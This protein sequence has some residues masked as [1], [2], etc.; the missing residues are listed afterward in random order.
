M[1]ILT[2]LSSAIFAPSAPAFANVKP[3]IVNVLSVNQR[4]NPDYDP[5]GIRLGDFI[6]HS[7][8]AAGGRYSDN[9]YATTR[10]TVSDYLYTVRPDLSIQSDFVRHG[11]GANVFAEKGIY[12]HES[13]EDYTDYKAQLNGRLDITGQTSLPLMI[14]YAKEHIRRG[15]PDERAGLEPTIYNLLESTAGLI[16]QGRALTIKVISAVRDYAY[17]NTRALFGTIDNS[18]Q[19]RTQWSLYTSVG[20]RD[21]AFFAPF[22]Y[23]DITTVGYDKKTDNRGN[24]RSSDG[25]EIGAGTVFNFSD[26]TR[27]S[28]S[29]GYINRSFDDARFSDESGLTYGLNLVWEP[30]TLASFQLE[31]KRTI[32]E[33]ITLNSSSSLTSTLNLTMTYELFPNVLIKP[34]VG[35]R[36]SEYQGIDRDVESVNAGVSMNYKLNR[37]L[38]L[39]TS[40][41]YITQDEKGRDA[42]VNEYNANT[43]NLSLKL[44][45]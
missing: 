6:L 14:S 32:D 2:L 26:I 23:S 10:N 29:A 1:V 18:D 16:H 4:L 42:G 37:N 43:Y 19:D 34:S 15:S 7:G 28:L 45:F 44:Q 3:K 25:Y 12:R 40:Y 39:S 33:T 24:K 36:L 20:M 13:N 38:W 22:V 5:I 9:V 21:D 11:L 30:S 17:E 27:A 35:Y 41:G 31:G 8:I